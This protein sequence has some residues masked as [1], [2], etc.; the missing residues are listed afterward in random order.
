MQVLH[1]DR[2]VA[3]PIAAEDG[4]AAHQVQSA[5]YHVAVGARALARATTSS[6]CS[7]IVSP[8]R[9]KNSRVK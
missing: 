8:M 5:S 2:R 7:P 6:T 1:V 4:M 3:T 9:W